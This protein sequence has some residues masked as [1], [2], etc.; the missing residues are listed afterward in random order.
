[1]KKAWLWICISLCLCL[2]IG[3]T[4]LP[5][6]AADVTS[7]FL[8]TGKSGV[9]LNRSMGGLTIT[10]PNYVICTGTL[11]T[12][13]ACVYTVSVAVDNAA[14]LPLQIDIVNGNGGIV[15]NFTISNSVINTVSINASSNMPVYYVVSNSN[16]LINGS[17]VIIS[18]TNL[19]MSSTPASF[20]LNTNFPSNVDFH[21][22]ESF[23]ALSKL[24]YLQVSYPTEMT[25]ATECVTV[26]VYAGPIDFAT[27][28]PAGAT[29]RKDIDL[30]ASIYDSENSY[31]PSVL[32]SENLRTWNTSGNTTYMEFKVCHINAQAG[33]DTQITLTL[34]ATL[35]YN[36]TA[37]KNSVFRTITVTGTANYRQIACVKGT[38]AIIVSAKSP[39]CPSGYKSANIPIKNGQLQKSTI[40]CI[41][42]LTIRTVTAIVPVCPAGYR[43]G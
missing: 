2:G 29:L 10:H 36:G 5:A 24:Q 12:S 22:T 18:A 28:Q 9:N 34:N 4:G 39:S 33:K 3:A 17:R 43:R 32:L 38:N 42:G 30:D 20:T 8:L 27:G 41:K 26:P 15:S 23:T 11:G 6:Q 31:S 7:T 14:V 35:R 13:T 21:T 16:S 37:L 25:S 19:Q 1:M 40:R